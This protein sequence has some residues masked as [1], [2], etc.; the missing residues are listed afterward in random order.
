MI[1]ARLRREL[2]LR[3]RMKRESRTGGFSG[4]RAMWL[5]VVFDLP[6]GSAKE[7][8]A[9]TQFRNLLKDEGFTMK[10]WSV[11][12]RYFDIRTRA[13]AAADRIGKQ[14]PSL[15][16]VSMMFLTDKQYGMTRNYHGRS[17]T[18]TEKKPEQLALF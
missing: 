13:E 10:Q 3:Y 18:E 14:T 9:A 1:D 2:S 5:L 4:Y 15:G 17:Q 8:R 16:S 7:R 11:Y 12:L 6:V